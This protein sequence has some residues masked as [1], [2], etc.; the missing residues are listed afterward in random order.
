MSVVQ[1]ALNWAVAI[2]KDQSHGY[3]Q[4]SR[5]GP[6]YDCSSF[7]ISAYKAAGVPINTQVVNYTGNMQGLLQYGFKDVTNQVNLSNGSGLQPG[8]ILWYHI[9]GTNGHTAMYAGNGKIVHA[10]GQSKGGPATGDQ[11]DEIGI[12][13]YSRSSWQ[14]VYRY[15]G[16]EAVSPGSSTPASTPMP[17]AP[18]VKRYALSTTLPII[19]KGNV[20]RATKVWQTIV[21][22]NADGEFGPNTHNATIQF[23]KANGLEVDGEVGPKTWA[24]GLGGVS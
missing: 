23:Q 1:N 8:D 5:W 21:G 11:G 15:A 10:R 19:K 3:S 20:G 22:V 13:N 17:A 24:A 16:S 2:A 14:H 6:D 12:T 18:T 4:Q 7:V 9:S